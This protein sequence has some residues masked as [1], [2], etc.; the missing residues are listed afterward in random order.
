MPR[1]HFEQNLTD[2]S[3]VEKVPKTVQISND[4]ANFER[5]V[6]VKDMVRFQ[7]K[8]FFSRDQ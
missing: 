4:F 8:L 7:K 3:H 1:T 2:G 6:R 5:D